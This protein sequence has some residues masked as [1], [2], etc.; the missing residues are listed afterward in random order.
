M[1]VKFITGDMF[2]ADTMAIVN[3]VNCVGVMGKG[4]ALE[5]KKRWPENFK[6]YKKKC[7]LKELEIGKV[8][9]FDNNASLFENKSD[10]EFLINF[11]TKKHWRSK[12]KIEYI[13]DGL[14]DFIVQVNKLGIKSVAIPPL[15]CGNGG[16]PWSEVKPI[17]IEKISE[18]PDVRWVVYEPREKVSSPE[19]KNI[20]K[21]LTVPRAALVKVLGDFA[22]FF[23]GSY[24]RLSIQKLVYFLQAM[25]IDFSLKF[26]KEVYGPYSKELHSALQ[27]MEKK[28][29]VTGYIEN[30][31]ITV[32]SGAY[33]AAVEYLEN[34]SKYV[35]PSL[36]K[37]SQL[38]EGFESPYGMELLSSVHYLYSVDGHK[39]FDQIASGICGWNQEKCEKFGLSKIKAAADRLEE[40]GLINLS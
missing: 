24:T 13:I 22:S 21:E 27:A 20:P 36:E 11:P 6:A 23:G 28:F 18:L 1:P 15:G 37:L 9:V 25:E 35:I 7:E 26:E 8:F 10:F 32:E 40:D 39:N 29:F 2:N 19:Y 30:E 33:A 38:I 5:F 31:E 17:I 34:N 16:L 3:T 12:S 14:E 4:V